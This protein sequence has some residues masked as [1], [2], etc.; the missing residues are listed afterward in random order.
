[1]GLLDSLLYNYGGWG[2][3]G[4]LIGGFFLYSSWA[5]GGANS[6]NRKNGQG[7]NGHNNNRGGGGG[8]GNGGGGGYGNGG[9]Y[10][11]GGGYF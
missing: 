11:G 8:Y 6:P 3:A 10:G 9:G 5:R 7:G 1:M 2:V 4:L